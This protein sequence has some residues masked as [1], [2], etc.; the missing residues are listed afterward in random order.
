MNTP[1]CYMRKALF[2]VFSL[3]IGIS[4]FTLQAAPN[5]L[6]IIADDLGTEALS[7]YGIGEETAVTPNIDKLVSQGVRFEQFWSQPS[8]SP[9]RAALLTGRYAFRTGVRS[10]LRFQWANMDAPVPQL[11]ENS[12]T[13]LW[14]EP[15]GLVDNG[16]VAA[17]RQPPPPQQLPRGPRLDEIMLPQVLG[18]LPDPY[19]T[20]AIGKWHLADLFN[21]DV[22]HPNQSG[23]DYYSGGL[24]GVPSSY[25]A[26]RH[27]ENGKL[28]TETG[29]YDQRVNDDAIHWI[30][31]QKEK[32]WFLWLSYSNPH[33]P[34]HLPPTELL[35]SEAKNLPPVFE[36]EENN[37]AY[38]YAQVEAM[39]TLI[40]QL[41]ESIPQEVKDNTYVI[42]LGDNGTVSWDNPSP[43]RDPQRAKGTV[44]EG[45]V[46]V[47]LII[48]GP[49]VPEGR[50]AT[51]LAHVVDLF[52]TILDLT[53]TDQDTA[54]P[55]SLAIDSISIAPQIFDPDM[56][57]QRSWVLTEG[58]L[59]GQNWTAIR[60]SQYKLVISDDREEFYDLLNDANETNILSLQGLMA[61]ARTAYNT[62]KSLL[63]TI[64]N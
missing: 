56:P 19:A 16:E 53:G 8:C 54:L 45:G 61:E 46:S 57:G 5:I 9:T 34:V 4:A 29:Y 27:L 58:S 17:L 49:G 51:P 30:A 10:P 63:D 28:T 1:S 36:G 50:T 42:F 24:F 18:A 62:L 41:L 6:V 38:F 47:P 37:R 35:H 44:Y 2:P 25:F 22:N 60:D 21:G 40:G 20:A 52:S 39:D 59:R 23:F 55:E 11:P 32:P 13:E 14:Y 43:P 3:S 64:V 15:I 31:E 48:A 33:T 7:S 26:W 12:P